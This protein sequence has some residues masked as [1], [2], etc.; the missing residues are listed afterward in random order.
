MYFASRVAVAVAPGTP[1]IGNV[2]TALPASHDTEV[3]RTFATPSANNVPGLAPNC[4]VSVVPASAAFAAP[5]GLAQIRISRSCTV[6]GIGVVFPLVAPISAPTVS[7]FQA[8]SPLTTSMFDNFCPFGR[9][10]EY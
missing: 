7:S 9:V 6:A 8:Y 2:T 3:S 5:C 1:G 10:Q 4:Q